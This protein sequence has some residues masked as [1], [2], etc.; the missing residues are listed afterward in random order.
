LVIHL[1][2]TNGEVADATNLLA[3]IAKLTPAYKQL[4]VSPGKKRL[5]AVTMAGG[6]DAWCKKWLPRS[7]D[8]TCEKC[9][10]EQDATD[11]QE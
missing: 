10:K 1:E 11:N 3:T 9:E 6:W 5:R 8:T 7:K 2:G 4:H